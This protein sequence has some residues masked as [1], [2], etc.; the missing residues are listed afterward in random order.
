VIRCVF[1][2]RELEALALALEQLRSQL[3]VLDGRMQ[4]EITKRRE[5][6]ADDNVEEEAEQE[7]ASGGASGA[8]SEAVASP[9]PT[10][11]RPVSSLVCSSA[12][13]S[14]AAVPHNRSKEPM[15]RARQSGKHPCVA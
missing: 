4:I 5:T 13:L 3:G 8:A 14:F 10:S 7:Q 11:S 15:C 9:S 2:Y 6:E 1:R 12:Q